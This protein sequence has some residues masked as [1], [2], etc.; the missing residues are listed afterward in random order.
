MNLLSDFFFFWKKWILKPVSVSERLDFQRT[1]FPL[2]TVQLKLDAYSTHILYGIV[3]YSFTQ[4]DN[5][6]KNSPVF[7]SLCEIFKSENLLQDSMWKISPVSRLCVCQMGDFCGG[8]VT[9]QFSSGHVN[10][11]V[12]A[13]RVKRLSH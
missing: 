3:K 11:P 5:S 12:T 9:Y 2:K 1:W 10:I 13:L 7:L 4:R 6:E 8:G